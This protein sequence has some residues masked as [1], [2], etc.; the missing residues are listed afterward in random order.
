MNKNIMRNGGFGKWVNEVESG[1]CPICSKVIESL[2]EFKDEISLKE[3]NMSGMCQM[4]QDNF[5][6]QEEE[7]I[8][9]RDKDF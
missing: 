2:K 3:F 6:E 5:F 8:I 9:L 1:R 7:Q 4:C